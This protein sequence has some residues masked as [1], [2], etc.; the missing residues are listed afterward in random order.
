[1]AQGAADAVEISGAYVRAVPPGMPNSAAFMEIRNGSAEDRA[2]VGAESSVS[3][4]AELHTHINDNGMMR[5]RQ[6]DRI[7]LPAGETVVLQPGGLHVMLIGLKRQIKPDDQVRITLKLEDGSELAVDAPVR[8]L[9]MKM[10]KHD[11][12]KQ[13]MH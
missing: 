4:V 12:M 9:Q 13:G 11:G 6:I 8:M 5:M 2:V 10:M 1:M 7:D 3:E